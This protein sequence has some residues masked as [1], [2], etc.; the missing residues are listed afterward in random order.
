MHDIYEG[1]APKE[2]KL[3]IGALINKKLFT[4]EELN[5]RI[6]SYSYGYKDKENRP[7]E[8]RKTTKTL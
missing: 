6:L 1:V 2:I 3:V 4:L 7:S 8:G 5:R